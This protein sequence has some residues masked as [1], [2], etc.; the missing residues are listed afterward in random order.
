M[1]GRE[2]ILSRL[3][4]LQASWGGQALTAGMKGAITGA[5]N[6][7]CDGDDGRRRVL[8]IVF[9][10]TNGS[11]QLKDEQW[12]ALYQWTGVHK[13]DVL[14]WVYDPKFAIDALVLLKCATITPCK[15]EQTQTSERS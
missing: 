15:N 8:S 12:W 5:M 14:G 7:A 11:K 9:P 1:D 6:E 3:A 2:V 13:D 4:G 10:G